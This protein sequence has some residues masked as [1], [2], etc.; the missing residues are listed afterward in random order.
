MYID[1]QFSTV[2]AFAASRA[3][4]RTLILD[5]CA[6]DR[7]RLRRSLS[8]TSLLLDVE[9]VA[10]L[11]QFEAA[12]RT[13]SYDLFLIDHRLP[14][15]NGLDALA[16]IRR[17]RSGLDAAKLMITGQVEPGLEAAAR[18]VG[19][20]GVVP[21]DEL[22]SDYLEPIMFDVLFGAKYDLLVQRNQSGEPP[23][24]M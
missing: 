7:A 20:Q 3:S 17:S 6:F 12:L 2:A 9:E 13:E 19:C 8:E 11:S 18:E 21:K 15:G 14:V 24:H 16:A 4:V 1:T 10:N 5:D 22:C 23:R